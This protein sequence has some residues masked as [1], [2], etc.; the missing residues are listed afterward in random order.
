MLGAEDPAVPF[1]PGVETS[2]ARPLTPLVYW[3][4]STAVVIARSCHR[5]DRRFR[6][7]AI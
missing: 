5:E 2:I 6:G 1:M 3:C 7:N 4:L